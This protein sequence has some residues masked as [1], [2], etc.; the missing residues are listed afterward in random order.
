MSDIVERLRT[1]ASDDEWMELMAQR[2]DAAAEIERLRAALREINQQRYTGR[3]TINLE[4]AYERAVALNA[5]L[6]AVMDIARTAL[7]EDGE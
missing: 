5:K 4:N 6:L 3:H 2:I 1:P 7:K